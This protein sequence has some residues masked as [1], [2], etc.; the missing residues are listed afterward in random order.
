MQTGDLVV[1]NPG[2]WV[3]QCCVFSI[4]SCSALSWLGNRIWYSTARI[5]N[6]W[7]RSLGELCVA[8]NMSSHAV[9]Y[10]G[11]S[12]PRMIFILS[13][14]R[15]AATVESARP[16]ITSVNTSGDQVRLV[17][18]MFIITVSNGVMSLTMQRQK[19]DFSSCCSAVTSAL[20]SSPLCRGRRLGEVLL[21][22]VKHRGH[23]EGQLWKRWR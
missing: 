9:K 7:L 17:N 16:E 13:L 11:G 21:R 3:P 23:G 19:R 15:V 10:A 4:S 6:H 2:S 12:R 20:F 8:P 1:L 14:C 22:E 18:L 5:E